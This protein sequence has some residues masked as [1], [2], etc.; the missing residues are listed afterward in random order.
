MPQK[1]A[2]AAAFWKF[3]GL[4]PPTDS[5]GDLRQG[6]YS[7]VVWGE[8]PRQVKLILLDTRWHRENHCIPSIATKIPLGAGIACATRWLSAGLFPNLCK[9]DAAM[10]GEQQWKWF[11]KQ[12][13]S[14]QAAVHIVVSSVQVLTTNPAMES[15]GHYPRERDRLIR[16]LSITRNV[17]LLSGDVHHGEIL[18]PLAAVHA[19]TISKDSDKERQ[20]Y[21]FLEVT[22]S[23]MT[24]DCSKHIYGK[25]CKPL[26]DI[27][28]HHRFA[29]VNNYFIGRNF[30]TMKIDWEAKT[31]ELSL[32]KETGESVLTTGIRELKSSPPDA[33]SD[34]DY[35]SVIPCMDGHLQP[36]AWSTVALLIG[37]SL[38]SR[39]L[40]KAQT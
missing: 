17:V 20:R 4:P 39:W 1:A 10:L 9:H 16:L 8:P 12:I 34:E 14:S 19:R 13:Y 40:R 38:L 7:S 31:M 27:F 15:W 11:E 32:R 37:S 5:N 30:G 3:L 22:S 18:D 21:G 26:L 23:G 2:R 33:W 25:M 24:H 6:V 29:D 35:R 36:L 28:H